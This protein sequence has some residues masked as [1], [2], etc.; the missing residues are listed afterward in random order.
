MPKFWIEVQIVIFG[1]SCEEAKKIKRLQTEKAE[2][3]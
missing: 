3:K 1:Q 2:I